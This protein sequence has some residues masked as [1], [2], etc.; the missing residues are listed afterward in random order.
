MTEAEQ[1][2]WL[3]QHGATVEFKR[4]FVRVRIQEGHSHAFTVKGNTLLAAIAGIRLLQNELDGSACTSQ[5]PSI[6]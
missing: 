2:Q 1:L 5:Q 4:K 6:E 3:E